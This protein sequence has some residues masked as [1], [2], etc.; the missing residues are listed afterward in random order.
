MIEIMN[1]SSNG[2]TESGSAMTL[3]C[4]E[5]LYSCGARTRAVNT[6][7]CPSNDLAITAVIAERRELELY[8]TTK[9]K[10]TK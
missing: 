9:D 7:I 6:E 4:P 2:I 5:N 10:V 8:Y 3:H 1:Q